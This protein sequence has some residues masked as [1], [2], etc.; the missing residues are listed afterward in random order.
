[1]L[2]TVAKSFFE[3]AK[4]YVLFAKVSRKSDITN[5]ELYTI[6]MTACK[7]LPHGVGKCPVGDSISYP[8]GRH[9]G[10]EAVVTEKSLRVQQ[11]GL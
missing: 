8:T 10:L 5:Y 11:R 2:E 1:M 4:E 9:S 7:G 6:Y 3:F